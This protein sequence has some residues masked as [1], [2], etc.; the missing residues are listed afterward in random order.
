MCWH[1]K[2]YGEGFQLSIP[3]FHSKLVVRTMNFNLDFKTSVGWLFKKSHLLR[4]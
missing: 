2:N 4:F 1:Y 3:R